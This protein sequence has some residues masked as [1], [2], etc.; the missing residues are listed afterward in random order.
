MTDVVDPPVTEPAAPS[1]RPERAEWPAWLRW[2]VIV[3]A[4]VTASSFFVFA[5]ARGQHGNTG[6]ADDPAVVQRQ[7]GPGA[8]VLQQE[9]V[10]A[11]LKPG[12]D[13]RVIINGVEVPEDQMAGAVDPRSSIAAAYGI[14]PNTK[15]DVLFLPG[16]GKV[17]EKLPTGE[18]MLSVRFWRISEGP[19]KSRSIS[20]RISVT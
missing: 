12:Y 5:T 13:G 4:L 9:Q 6:P 16:K 15:Q 3:M 8:R 11:R 14:R 7:P 1:P 19:T 20:W 17:M 10:G 18:V 2:S